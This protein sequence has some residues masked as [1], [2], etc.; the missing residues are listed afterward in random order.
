MEP[1]HKVVSDKLPIDIS[2]LLLFLLLSILTV[3]Y[4]ISRCVKRYQN[5]TV[6]WL[7]MASKTENLVLKLY[8]LPYSS[9][10]YTFEIKR[11]LINLTPTESLWGS[12]LTWSEWV[13]VKVTLLEFYATFPQA[14]FIPFWKQYNIKH[15]M[16]GR[17]FTVLHVTGQKGDLKSLK[18]CFWRVPSHRK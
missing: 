15:I 8:E 9:N 7:E 2:I 3:V 13:K 18:I 1:Y 4:V 16:K 6:V 14:V 10:F 12:R 17:H 5:H 11:T